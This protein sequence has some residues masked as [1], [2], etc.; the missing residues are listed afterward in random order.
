MCTNEFTITI[1]LLLSILNL[2]LLFLHFYKKSHLLIWFNA[3]FIIFT[4]EFLFNLILHMLN[5]KCCER[6]LW[7]LFFFQIFFLSNCLFVCSILILNMNFS[8]RSTSCLKL[9]SLLIYLIYVSVIFSNLADK[10]RFCNLCFFPQFLA[11]VAVAIS[12]TL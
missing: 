12:S 10:S 1:N 9:V 6:V 3:Q 7:I 2:H 4:I 5:C 11:N 8:C